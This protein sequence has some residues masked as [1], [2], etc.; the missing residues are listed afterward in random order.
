[1][2]RFAAPFVLL[3][4]LLFGGFA[5][6]EE[7]WQTLP[8]PAPMPK[9]AESGYAKVNGIDMYYAVYGA[10]DPVLLIHGGLGS[11]RYLVEP[12]LRACQDA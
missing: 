2:N 7:R 11:C 8:E 3:I 4:L 12:G 10:G 6:A 9:A 5:S 1:M